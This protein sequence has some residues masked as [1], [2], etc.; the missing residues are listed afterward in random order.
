[1][2]ELIFLIGY[3]GTGKTT[4][5]PILAERLRWKW[6][7]ADAVLE[8]RQG[9]S[10]ASI[11]EVEG[12]AGFR[13]KEELL[14]E[15]LCR[16]RQHV[17]AA[18]GGVILRATNRERLRS[19]GLVV[20]LKADAEII[21]SRIEQDATTQ[22]RRPV[23]TVGGLAE[24][25]ELLRVRE[26]LYRACADCIVETTNRSPEEVADQIWSLVVASKLMTEM[27]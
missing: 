20:W 21:R 15:E 24:V 26:P 2:N 5:A 19:A 22:A 1:M 14:M 13:A 27:D 16:L 10:I 11:F 17:V 25:K 3:R 23:L 8:E 7:D 9:R 18:G 6:V 4:V 12:E